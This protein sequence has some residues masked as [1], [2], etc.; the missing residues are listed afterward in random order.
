V[1]KGWRQFDAQTTFG[2]NLPAADTQ[3][4][5]RQLVWNTVFQYRAGWKLWPEVETNS[6]FYETGPSAGETQTF[7]TPGLGFGRVTLYRGLRFSM[8]G[9]LQIAVTQFHTYN[10]RWMLSVRF[11]F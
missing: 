7:L 8:A 1:G 9:G 3:R 10:H 5:G 2:I 11:P 4:L 6:T